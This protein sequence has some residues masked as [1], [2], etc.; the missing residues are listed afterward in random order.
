MT[1]NDEKIFVK[2]PTFDG[3]KSKWTFFKS[4]MISYLA[5]KNMGEMLTYAEEIENDTKS[6]SAD[7]R[8]T[9]EVKKAIKMRTMNKKAAGVLLNCMDT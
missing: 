3:R 4:K 6:W 7:E 2:V 8:K 9:D 5:Q 1:D